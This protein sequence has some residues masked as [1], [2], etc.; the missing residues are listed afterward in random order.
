MVFP[1]KLKE[2]DSAILAAITI[3]LGKAYPQLQ[4][5]KMEEQK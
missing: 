4:I 2:D 3:H 5:T 1:E